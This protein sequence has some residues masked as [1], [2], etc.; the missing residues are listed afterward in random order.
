M[1]TILTYQLRTAFMD[2][3]LLS[4]YFKYV[5]DETISWMPLEKVFD[6]IVRCVSTESQRLAFTVSSSADKIKYLESGKYSKKKWSH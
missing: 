6:P 1:S 5:Q 4:R 3:P 2:G